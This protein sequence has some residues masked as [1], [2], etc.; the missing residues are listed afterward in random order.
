MLEW[1]ETQSTSPARIDLLA[2]LVRSEFGDGL[3]IQ[4]EEHFRVGFTSLTLQAIFAAKLGVVHGCPM[5]SSHFHR[6]SIMTTQ[7]WEV[8]EIPELGQG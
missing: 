6:F 8:P 5:S 2:I 1:T 4:L 3:D 7:V